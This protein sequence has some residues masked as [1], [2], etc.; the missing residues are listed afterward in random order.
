MNRLISLLQNVPLFQ[1]LSAAELE[2]ISPLF[3][4]RT[5]KKNTVLFVEGDP[6][7]EFFFSYKP[8]LSRFTESIM[9]RKLSSPCSGKVI[10][11]ERWR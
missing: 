6:G 1:D 4:E 7:E 2:E 5:F 8:G 10:S 9:P 3:A 11:L